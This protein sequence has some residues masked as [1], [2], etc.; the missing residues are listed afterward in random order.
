MLGKLIKYDI[1]SM[2]KSFVPLWIA[3]LAVS[4]INRFT[5]NSRAETP[6]VISM[7]LYSGLMVAVVVLAI[8]LIINR[9]YNGLLKDEGYL[10]FTL[11]VKTWQLI[12]SKCLTALI[13]I[14]LSGLI[15]LISIAVI[16]LNTEILIELRK[17][18]AMIP[19]F[20]SEQIL[21]CVLL[22]VL[23][24]FATIDAILHVYAAGALGQLANKHRT[25]WAVAAY[26]AIS[27]L[28]SIITS[29][30]LEFFFD[31]GFFEIFF[32][33][34]SG[35]FRIVTIW[36][37]YYVVRAALFFVTTERLLTKKLNLE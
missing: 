32:H 7:I 24:L 17:V 11:P 35:A 9:F 15:G 33:D 6:A 21:F 1:R 22:L 26:I 14:L 20:T 4:V 13:V 16:A 25:G 28:F 27:T 18:L 10:M 2:L 31:N 19:E 37:I 23:A 36:I 29:N 30:S 8:T 34:L 3:L 5:I 12:A